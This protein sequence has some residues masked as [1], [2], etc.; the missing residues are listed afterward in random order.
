MTVK[1]RFHFPPSLGIRSV[2]WVVPE[3]S[4]V[5]QATLHGSPNT[6]RAGEK[7]W[8]PGRWLIMLAAAEGFI[9]KFRVVM[10]SDLANCNW[11]VS[12]SQLGASDACCNSNIN[13]AYCILDTVC[14]RKSVAPLGLGAQLPRPAERSWLPVRIGAHTRRNCTASR[15]PTL[16]VAIL[17]SLENLLLRSDNKRYRCKIVATVQIEIGIVILITINIIISVTILLFIS[18]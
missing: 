13:S 1:S 18:S 3:R 2:D 6:R 10:R 5:V 9:A 4:V 12:A 7:A 8:Q 17:Q 14:H 16:H 15:R 11:T